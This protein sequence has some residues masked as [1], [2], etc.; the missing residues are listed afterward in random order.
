MLMLFHGWIEALEE[1]AKPGKWWV[2]NV[3]QYA[4]LGTAEG[5]YDTRPKMSQSKDEFEDDDFRSMDS[6]MMIFE[7]WYVS[8][9][10]L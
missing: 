10:C 6:R 4:I 8:L 2:T 3:P 9:D 1:N 5:S 7:G